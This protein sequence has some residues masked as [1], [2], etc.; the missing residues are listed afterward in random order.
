[1]KTPEEKRWELIRDY[2]FAESNGKSHP[3]FS[4]QRTLFGIK[5]EVEKTIERAVAEDEAARKRE[6]DARKRD[7]ETRD[8]QACGEHSSTSDAQSCIDPNRQAGDQGQSE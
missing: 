3:R 4:S 8:S 7:D 1:M 6:R 5:S 2:L